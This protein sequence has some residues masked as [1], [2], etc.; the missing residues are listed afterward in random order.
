[1]SDGYVRLAFVE[2]VHRGDSLYVLKAP[3]TLASIS[4]KD[5]DGTSYVLPPYL[6]KDSLGVVYDIVDLNGEHNNA[7]FSLRYVGDTE[8]DGFL[9]ESFDYGMKM[10][11]MVRLNIF[12]VS[13][14]SKVHG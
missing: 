10:K 12:L 13:V 5:V 7:A 2:A 4:V 8:N 9:L 1:M 11:K 3:Y 14:H 6:S